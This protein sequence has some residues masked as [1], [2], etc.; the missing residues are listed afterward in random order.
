M[1]T[2]TSALHCPVDQYTLGNVFICV[3]I[4]CIHCTVILRCSATASRDREREWEVVDGGLRRRRRIDNR[5]QRWW[6]STNT[7]TN[8]HSDE[9]D[10]WCT[11]H[12]Y[13]TLTHK[14]TKRNCTVLRAHNTLT[15]RHRS[16]KE[17]YRFFRS[18]LAEY[19]TVLTLHTY[20]G[21]GNG[22]G[23]I[24]LDVR[25]FVCRMRIYVCLVA[26]VAGTSLPFQETKIH[27][28][29]E[30]GTPPNISLFSILDFS[31]VLVK[32]IIYNKSSDVVL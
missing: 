13:T 19:V 15:H 9:R 3:R 11:S 14:H 2:P 30:C 10:E 8:T 28:T 26:Y 6:V 18:C 1:T 22:G 20:S 7:H 4:D 25:S 31:T 21:G 12:A 32:T 29:V 24:V 17:R 23:S 5:R 27:S 16:E